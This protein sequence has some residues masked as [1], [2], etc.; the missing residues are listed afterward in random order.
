MHCG[1]NTESPNVKLVV[2]N[3]L[4]FKSLRQTVAGGSTVQLILNLS[5]RWRWVVNLTPRRNSLRYPLSKRL[6]GAVG[7]AC[8]TSGSHPRRCVRPVNWS[9][10]S[11]SSVLS[12]QERNTEWNM[13]AHQRKTQPV[14]VKNSNPNFLTHFNSTVRFFFLNF[15]GSTCA[16]LIIYNS[17]PT[18]AL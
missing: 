13:W 9:F 18:D 6:G 3:V 8:L 14:L 1:Q 7:V 16:F 12:W 17:V 10:V 11:V 2:H 15:N 5:T 4:G